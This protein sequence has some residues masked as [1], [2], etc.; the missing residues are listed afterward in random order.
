[1]ASLASLSLVPEGRSTNP[2]VRVIAAETGMPSG[3]IA[4]AR[5]ASALKVAFAI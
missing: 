2:D 3:P 4:N 1:M 5:V